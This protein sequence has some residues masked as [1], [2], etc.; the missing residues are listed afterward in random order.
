MSGSPT[1]AAGP[2][3]D[4]PSPDAGPSGKALAVA[5]L[6]CGVAGLFTFGL[7]ALAGLA[8]GAAALGRAGAGAGKGKGLAVAGLIVSGLA[9]PVGVLIG[10][11]PIN[12]QFEEENHAA[13]R[14]GMKRLANACFEYG[15]RRRYLFPPPQRWVD[16]LRPH[17]ESDFDQLLA[18]PGEPDAGRAVAMNATLCI[19]GQTDE[20]SLAL[21]DLLEPART[22]LF[23]ECRPGA[24]PAGG[25]ELLPE[26]PRYAGRYVI[27]F[28]DG[29]VES[30]PPENI[31]NLVWDGGLF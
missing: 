5:S 1:H 14:N 17:A 8:L 15:S 9:L 4:P 22:V 7:S 24:P 6:V 13:F 25:P 26:K 11:P 28:C 10:M 27:A 20:P 21:T 3:P 29:H 18:A 16:E 12:S 30:V 23:F 2:S 19:P 31:D